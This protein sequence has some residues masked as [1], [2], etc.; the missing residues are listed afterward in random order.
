MARIH[1]GELF[2]F[3]HGD[4]NKKVSPDALSHLRR[5]LVAGIAFQAQVRGTGMFEELRT[6]KFLQRFQV[7]QPWANGLTAP[8]KTRHEVRLDLTR[9]NFDVGVEITRINIDVGLLH[10]ACYPP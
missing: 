1:T 4:V 3:M 9:E 7:R 2:L 5:F 8:R 10:R 6:V